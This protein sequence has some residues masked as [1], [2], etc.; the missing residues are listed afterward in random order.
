[1]SFDPLVMFETM[2]TMASAFAGV[3]L[4]IGGLVVG[5]ALAELVTLFL[6]PDRRRHP[7]YPWR[8][9]PERKSRRR[10]D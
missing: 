1:M 9:P 4:V 8:T 6:R 5:L 3:A 2:G 10:D 7:W